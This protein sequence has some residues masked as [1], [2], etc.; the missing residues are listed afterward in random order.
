MDTGK[1]AMNIVYLSN[2]YTPVLPSSARSVET[3]IYLLA[4]EQAKLGHK[5]VIIDTKTT[6]SRGSTHASF[7]ELWTDRKSVV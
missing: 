3:S 6:E 2:G 4:K 7:Y 1:G 5:V